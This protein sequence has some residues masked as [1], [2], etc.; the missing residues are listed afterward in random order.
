MGTEV[1]RSPIWAGSRTGSALQEG[2]A[3]ASALELADVYAVITYL[4][5]HPEE[6][7]EYLRSRE[8]EAS[9]VRGDVERF[10]AH[11]LLDRIR[12]NP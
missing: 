3:R 10:R 12:R 6:V 11:H 9:R 5:R 8:Q 1:E 7:E 2:T 4:L